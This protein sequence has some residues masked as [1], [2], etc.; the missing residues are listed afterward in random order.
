MT[1]CGFFFSLPL[2]HR[3]LSSGLPGDRKLAQISFTSNL[4]SFRM[5][6][7]YGP[8]ESRGEHSCTHTYLT[9]IRHW[10]PQHALLPKIC[11]SFP[12]VTN[13]VAGYKAHAV[14]PASRPH[15]LSRE[16]NTKNCHWPSMLCIYLALIMQ[17]ARCETATLWVSQAFLPAALT[18]MRTSRE[19]SPCS[20]RPFPPASLRVRCPAAGEISTSIP[21]Q[22]QYPEH[23][24]KQSSYGDQKL[25]HITQRVYQPW[26]GFTSWSIFFWHYSMYTP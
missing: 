14:R 22:A 9:L 15:C 18:L 26:P 3:T 19:S 6:E 10:I 25:S 23:N 16:A 11:C 8:R 5:T 7:P 4:M 20:V 2:S 24:H 12:Y 13:F 17:S 1:L 21:D